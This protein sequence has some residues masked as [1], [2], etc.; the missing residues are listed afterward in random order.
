M[1]GYFLVS[2]EILDYSLNKR[3]SSLAS[4]LILPGIKYIGKHLDNTI[5]L[6]TLF[7]QISGGTMSEE[8]YRLIFAQFRANIK[9]VPFH[10]I[11]A[12]KV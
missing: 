2:F 6:F 5:K 9:S 8:G 4:Q 12:Q 10:L 3:R 7:E 1:L 11:F